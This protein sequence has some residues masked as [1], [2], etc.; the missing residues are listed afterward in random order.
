MQKK[1]DIGSE[2][3]IPNTEEDSFSMKL[4]EWDSFGFQ[5]LSIKMKKKTISEFYP[6]SCSG[7]DMTY[8]KFDDA[9]YV[10]GGISCNSVLREGLKQYFYKLK[11][12]VWT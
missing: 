4:R 9:I 5:N 2:I 7:Y 1:I 11:N 10:Y 3:I 6:P 8:C 12:E